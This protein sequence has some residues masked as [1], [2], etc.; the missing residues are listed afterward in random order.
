MGSYQLG[1]VY[2]FMP[3]RSP[4]CV[5]GSVF[6]CVSVSLTVSEA[7]CVRPCVRPF[8]ETVELPITPYVEDYSLSCT[9]CLPSTLAQPTGPGSV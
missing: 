8:C 4:M 2:I 1:C 5:S 7:V 9:C 6:R 3:E